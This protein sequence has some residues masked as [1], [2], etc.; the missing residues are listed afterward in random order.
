MATKSR[1]MTA[2]ERA[3]RARIRS[4]ILAKR[5]AEGEDEEII[6]DDEEIIED[7]EMTEE[8]RRAMKRA[9]ARYLRKKAQ[10]EEIVKKDDESEDEETIE[11]PDED[12]EIEARRRAARRRAAIRRAQMRRRAQEE[13]PIPEKDEEEIEETKSEDEEELEAKRC[14]A[15]RRAR[16][17]ARRRA[18][19]RRRA[20]E[21]SDD[22]K[23]IDG[24]S[25]NIEELHK[26]DSA[27]DDLVITDEEDGGVEQIPPASVN[28]AEDKVLNAYALIEA[29]IAQNIIPANVRKSSLAS[30]YC[31][32]YTAREMKVAAEQLGKVGSAGKKAGNV[33]VSRRSAMPT[34][35]AATK[36]NFDEQCIFA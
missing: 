26:E 25:S 29:Q 6:V 9:Y 33:R 27:S 11:E 19:M 3:R 17:M 16:M 21:V 13:A 31:K 34:K 22:L 32:K 23:D 15:R 36:S 14:A 18:A 24:D 4:Q 1:T 35:T 30:Q 7:E 5:A 12:K 2:A 10:E 20:Q 28:E 8:A